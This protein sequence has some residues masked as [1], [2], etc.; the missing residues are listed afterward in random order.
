MA[1]IQH[2]FKSKELLAYRIASIHNLAYLFNLMKRMNNAIENSYFT[3]FSDS[4]LSRYESTNS[5]VQ[6]QQKEK[7][8]K[9]N[10]TKS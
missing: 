10:K 2:L 7:W 8:L 3:E 1:Y 5:T 4:F 6:K 9:S